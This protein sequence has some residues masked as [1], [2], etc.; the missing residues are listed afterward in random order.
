MINIGEK[1][2]TANLKI[3]NSEVVNHEFELQT[4]YNNGTTL[5]YFFPAA[6]TG[7]CTK[8]SC[9]LRDDLNEYQDMNV[10][11]FGI[12]V[13]SPFVLKKFHSENSLNYSLLSDWN[14]NAIKAFDII[15]DDFAGGLKGFGKRSLFLIKDGELIFKWIADNPGNNPPFEEL[16]AK[17]R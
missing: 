9:E 15:D 14:K 4:A 7:V 3:V 12:S 1:A 11:I 5:L 13:D 2:P 8:S 17:L 16:K 10:Q 6:F